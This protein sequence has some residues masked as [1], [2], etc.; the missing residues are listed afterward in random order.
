MVTYKK[1]EVI[2]REGVP[3]NFVSILVKGTAMCYK[4]AEGGQQKMVLLIQPGQLYGFMT[5]FSPGENTFTVEA[6]DPCKNLE[7]DK[8]RLKQLLL[9]KPAI[10]W[11]LTEEIAGGIA[12]YAHLVETQC[13][14]VEERICKSLI[15]LAKQFGHNTADGIE[16]QINLTQEKLAICAGTTRVTA[17]R[18]L[19]GLIEQG[20]VRVKPK[21]WVICRIDSLVKS[22]TNMSITQPRP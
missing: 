3:A 10:L 2:I 9:A 12:N 1:R 14:T 11:K 13:L 22:L 8:T 15:N 19:S 6:L 4:T 21:P 17:A 5:L 7:I 16:L 18:I 20:I